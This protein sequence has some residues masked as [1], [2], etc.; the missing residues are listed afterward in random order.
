MRRIKECY[1]LIFEANLSQTKVAEILQIGRSTVWDYLAKLNEYN[2]HWDDIRSL[3]E[4]DLTQRLFSRTQPVRILPDFVDLHKQLQSDSTLTLQILWEEYKKENPTGYA[5]GQFCT[6]YRHWRKRLR[7]YM[8]QAHIG[9]EKVFADYSGK[10]PR[11][12]NQFSGEY[13]PMELFVMAWGVSHFLY[14]E[15][16]PSQELEHWIMGHVRAFE[17]FG[18]VPRIV[19]PDNLKSAVTKSH[20][21]DPDVNRTYTDLA[22]HYGI[23][24]IPAR[25]R[26]PK[27]KAKVENGVQIV[28]RWIL[29]RLRNCKFD[30]IGSLNEAIR[31]LLDEINDKPMQILKQ[32][33]RE[34]FLELDRPNALFLPAQGFVF[35]EWK[36]PTICLD[37]H[38]D[39]DKHY[40]SVPHIWYGHDVDVRVCENTVEVFLCKTK[41]RIATHQR[42]SKQYG[43][44]TIAEHMPQ[45]HQK[46]LEWTPARLIQWGHKTGRNTGVLIEKIITL[47]A[48]P[49]QGFRPALGILRLGQAFGVDRLE[50]AAAIALQHNLYRVKQINEILKK[51]L[52]KTPPDALQPT[53]TVVNT[54]NVRGADYYTERTVSQ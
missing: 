50:A 26:K 44:T 4:A 22:E 10:R 5:Y 31:K 16:Q 52:D 39:I 40:Y 15:A 9:G 38:I 12:Y 8:R 7:T 49:Q 34:R 54:G 53:G 11:V 6:Y 48:H 35:H 18:C 42:N 1:R 29:A 17:Y 19:V 2:L 14:A 27:D 20:R 25:P 36:S 33:R 30:S 46:H 24:I 41:E 28:Q 43:Y 51:G 3:S 13:E 37:Y 45:A 21:Y 47:K 32:T 23:G